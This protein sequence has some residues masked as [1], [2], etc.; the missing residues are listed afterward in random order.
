MKP[1]SELSPRNGYCFGSDCLGNSSSRILRHRGSGAD[2]PAYLD[3]Y[4]PV[5]RDWYFVST[6]EWGTCYGEGGIFYF[7]PLS[8]QEAA[9]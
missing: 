1:E 7:I 8:P 5:E 2:G 4:A 6:R 9:S 3:V